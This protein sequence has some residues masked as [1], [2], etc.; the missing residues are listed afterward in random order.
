MTWW[1]PLADKP[2]LRSRKPKM[3]GTYCLPSACAKT[4]APLL[5]MEM[6]MA[7]VRKLPRDVRDITI[8]RIGVAF[9]DKDYCVVEIH[10]HL[11]RFQQEIA[12]GQELARAIY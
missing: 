6:E 8:R 11:G 9:I 5:A 10:H 1:C 4:L 3:R 7:L 12:L 2:P